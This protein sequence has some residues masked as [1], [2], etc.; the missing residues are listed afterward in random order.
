MVSDFSDD[1]N[2]GDVVLLSSFL[3]FF[4]L[5][6]LEEKTRANIWSLGYI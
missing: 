6:F 4:Q 2:G 3:F 5:I 1:A